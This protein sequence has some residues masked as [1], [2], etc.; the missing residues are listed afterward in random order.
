MRLISR[1]SDIYEANFVIDNPQTN[2]TSSQW[3]PLK[4]AYE[5]FIDTRTTFAKRWFTSPAWALGSRRV[6]FES[7]NL[8]DFRYENL[9]IN[10]PEIFI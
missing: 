3:K 2:E 6:L 1:G 8:E 4:S 9:L 5:H 7:D 10:H